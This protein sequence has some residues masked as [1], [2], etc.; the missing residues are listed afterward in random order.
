MGLTGPTAGLVN[1]DI[2]VDLGAGSSIQTL[3]PRCVEAL[4]LVLEHCGL[5]L[6]GRACEILSLSLG[7]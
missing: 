7:S 4:V 5:R 1:L 2:A 3:G 6:G